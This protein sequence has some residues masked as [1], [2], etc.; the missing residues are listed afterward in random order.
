MSERWDPLPF[1]FFQDW[2]IKKDKSNRPQKK[3]CSPTVNLKLFPRNLLELKAR[4]RKEIYLH[5]S[6]SWLTAVHQS[7][8]IWGRRC[9][10]LRKTHPLYP[11]VSKAS[12]CEPMPQLWKY[13]KSNEKQALRLRW[14]IHE[15]KHT[16]NPLTAHKLRTTAGSAFC[17]VWKQI[18][19]P[20]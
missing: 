9:H 17:S 7:C 16:G 6:G 15:T 19:F 1:K 18:H 5:K 12:C 20:T 10:I 4:S 8:T 11:L 3:N 13:I 14:S 2:K